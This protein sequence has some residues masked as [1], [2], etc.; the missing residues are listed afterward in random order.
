MCRYHPARHIFFNCIF[1]YH[2]FKTLL[3]KIRIFATLFVTKR[4]DSMSNVINIYCDES[5]HLEKDCHK[6]MVIGGISCPIEKVKELSIKIRQ[7]KEKY[8]LSKYNEIKWTKVSA[9]KKSF[10]VEL[11]E[12]FYNT[13]YLKF[14]AVKIPDKSVLNHVKFCQTHDSWYYKMYYVMLRHILNNPNYSYNVYMDIKDSCSSDKVRT[15]KDFLLNE[16]KDFNGERLHNFQTIRSNE[17]EL[18]QLADLLIGAVGYENRVQ[19]IKDRDET[20]IPNADKLFLVGLLKAKM[21]IVSFENST[22]YSA[23]K[24]NILVWEATKNA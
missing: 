10:F 21:H 12:L 15:L 5:C 14:R 16:I 1:C 13:E 3:K 18:L 17:S 23:D 7:L 11:I 9:S 19:E 24:F 22:P 2:K 8:G 20:F 6:S 4:T